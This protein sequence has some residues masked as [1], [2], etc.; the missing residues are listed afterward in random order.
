MKN[1]PVH[2]MQRATEQNL[3]YATEH[4][5]D[6][7]PNQLLELEH[8][9]QD[10]ALSLAN[11]EIRL[12]GEH[13]YVTHTGLLNV[14]RRRRCSG[15]SVAVDNSL[16][17]PVS[18]R[19]V[20]Q[21]TV[22]ISRDSLG[23]IGYGDANPQNIPPALRGAE[24]RI[25]ETRAVN[26]AI[27]KAYGIGTCSVEELGNPSPLSRTP[28]RESITPVR[29]RFRSIIREYGLDSSKMKLFAADYCGTAQ[30]RDAR[31]DLVEEFIQHVEEMATT[32][33]DALICKLNSYAPV[34]EAIA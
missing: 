32:D 27:R 34:E 19:W 3:G 17:D 9:S 30:L 16:S 18:S 5:P 15:I 11:G 6:L 21:A 31:R 23:F 14:A 22:F 26:R 28:Q 13:W 4:F 1:Q 10:F 24:L 7:T 25:A 12:I 33:R 2:R 29:D 8:L 20:M